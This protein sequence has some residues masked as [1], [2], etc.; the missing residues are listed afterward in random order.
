M[1]F[2]ML[3]FSG[4]AIGIELEL[5]V[6]LA[7]ISVATMM[8]RVAIYIEGWGLAQAASVLVFTLLGL[9]VEQSLS[10]SLLSDAITIVG[11]LPGLVLLARDAMVAPPAVGVESGGR[12]R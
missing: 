3:Y 1:Q 11:S 9:T 8:R 4:R 5:P 6:F 10:L 2:S 7:G 12:D